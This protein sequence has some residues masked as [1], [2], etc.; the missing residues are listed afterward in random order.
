M[1]ILFIADG[2]SPI[3]RNWIDYFLDQGLDVHLASTF[4]CPGDPRLASLHLAPVAFSSLK[5]APAASQPAQSRRGLAGGA[6]VR[7]RTSVRQWLGP[8]TIPA[9]ARR[10]AALVQELQPDLV[11]AMRI[12][13]EGM[14]AAEALRGLPSASRPPLLVSIW[15]NDFTLHAPATPLM[16]R[17]TRQCL[18]TASALHSDCYRD[19]RLAHAWG[20]AAEK[21]AAVLPGAGG[22]Q[23]ELFYSQPGPRP[24]IAINP[25]GVRAYVQNE[26]FFHA[27]PLVLDHRP[28]ARFI[29]TTMAGDPQAMRWVSALGLEGSVEL[30]PQQPRPQMAVL[31]RQARLAVSPSTH[32]GTPN[33]LLEAM[34]CGAL[35]VAGDLESIREWITPGLNGLLAD[36]RDPHSLAQ[37]M[38]LGFEQ[39]GLFERAQPLNARLIAARAAYPTVM[40]QAVEFYRSLK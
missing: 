11:H 21:P 30:L 32:D 25:R 40:A 2:R 4:A 23:P 9:A 33:T 16:R 7:L 31:F 38:L 39:D 36:P 6:A 17:L 26:A 24:P 37:A 27:L 5:A 35:P 19:V 18:E 15:G 12:P 8:L 29:C 34:A 14:L 13:Y 20:F 28:D 10:L 3:A 1:R 22:V